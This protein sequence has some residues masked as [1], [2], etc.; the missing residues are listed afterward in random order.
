MR[1]SELNCAMIVQ[2]DGTKL[3]RV[4]EVE[5]KGGRIE[6]LLYGESGFITRMTG[7]DRGKHVAWAKV[8]KVTKGKI[9]LK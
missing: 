2:A 9:L 1:L 3:G 6:R 4:H 8:A 7:R 5:V